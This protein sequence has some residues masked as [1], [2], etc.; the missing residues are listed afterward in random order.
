MT[1]NTVYVMYWVPSGYS[2]PSNVSSLVDG[3]LGDVAT[4]NGT[5]GNVFADATQ[6][7]V[8]YNATFGGSAIDTNAFPHSDLNNDCGGIASNIPTGKTNVCID[9]QQIFEE[10]AGFASAQG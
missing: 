9:E 10:L 5:T 1:S 4:D 8:G 2:F 3:F 6:Y 7:G